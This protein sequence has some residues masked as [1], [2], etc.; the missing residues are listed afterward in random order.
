MTLIVETGAGVSGAD[1]FV[2]LADAQ[3]YI[4]ARD[5]SV[6]L[7]EGHLLRAMDALSSLPCLS[8][9][10]LPLAEPIEIPAALINAQI[11]IA[12]YLGAGAEIDR[13]D[14]ESGIIREKV[15]VIETE[16]SPDHIKTRVTPA[17]LPNVVG[18]LKVLGC[19]PLGFP[20]AG[21]LERA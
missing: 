10:A 7:T 18:Q 9:Y 8:A 16:Y 5:L 17:D 19:S 13:A 3:A 6:T 1:S 11:W 15:D 4:T 2:S 20:T 21:R 12:Y 14:T